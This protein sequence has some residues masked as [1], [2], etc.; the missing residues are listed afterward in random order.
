M[1]PKSS[2]SS[3]VLVAPLFAKINNFFAVEV[4]SSSRVHVPVPASIFQSSAGVMQG[5]EKQTC[6][7]HAFDAEGYTSHIRISLF[8]SLPQ[9]RKGCS[10]AHSVPLACSGTRP[11]RC[12]NRC[13]KS[14]LLSGTQG[15]GGVSSAIGEWYFFIV[16]PT[17]FLS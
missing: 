10:A 12:S 16:S 9:W 17:L 13:G 1:F 14:K 8:L 15:E 11:F 5:Q 7:L 4:V 2:R 6:L 3:F